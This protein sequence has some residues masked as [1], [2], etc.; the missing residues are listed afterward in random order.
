[1]KKALIYSYAFCRSGAIL[2]VPLAFGLGF[3]AGLF[4]FQVV[5]VGIYL[6]SGLNPFQ[7]ETMVRLIFGFSVLVGIFIARIEF[8]QFD[9]EIYK[10]YLRSINAISNR[11]TLSARGK[12]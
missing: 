3:F 6:A 10:I 8:E 7:D 5:S 9:S 11:R 12:R 2:S 4:G 1:M